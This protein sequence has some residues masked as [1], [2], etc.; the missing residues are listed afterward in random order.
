MKIFPVLLFLLVGINFMS[1]Q[2]NWEHFWKQSTPIKTWVLLHPFK[3]KNAYAISLEAQKITDS[4]LTT[5]L[6]DKD[7]S[8]GQVDAFRHAFWMATLQI[9]IGKCAAKSLGKAHERDNNRTFKKRKLENGILPDKASKKMDLYNNKVGLTF[10]KK[11]DS[12]SIKS[13]IYKISNSILRGDLKVIKKDSLGNYLTCANEI[14]PSK[15]LQHKWKNNKC[16]VSSK[17]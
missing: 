10:S 14:I 3:A 13:L 11:G 12:I 6:L 2:S 5:T 4:I 8:G 16:L 7:A 15:E 9:E 1:A 17:K